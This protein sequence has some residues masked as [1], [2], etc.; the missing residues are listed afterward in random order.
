M[1]K[2]SRQVFIEI[3]WLTVSLGFTFLL[4][5]FL[6]GRNFLS[7]TIDIHL[8]DTYFVIAPFHILLSIF[9]LVTFIVYFI[10]EFRNSFRQTF[11][12]W[13]LIVIGLMLVIALTF[14]IKTFSQFF[15]GGWT[16]YPPLSA[17]GPDKIPELTHDSVT[18]FITSFFTVVQIIVLTMLLFVAFRWGTQK[19]DWKQFFS[20][21]W[22]VSSRTNLILPIQFREDTNRSEGIN[23]EL[24]YF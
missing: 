12:N 10:K 13:I 20:T 18:K 17:L 2:V 15:T 8:H 11:S 19:R 4:S 1:Q 23:N 3:I 9:L 5:L 24:L 21:P 22:F 6:F 16:L 7:D 14:L